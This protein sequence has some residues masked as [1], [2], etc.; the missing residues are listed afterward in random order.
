[1]EAIKGKP[2]S[3]AAL[4]IGSSK[5]SCF[6]GQQHD[7]G[8]IEILGVGHQLAKGIK[9]GQVTDVGEAVE[10][11]VAAVHAAERMAE[12]N[13]EH[14]FV[15]VNGAHVQSRS[16]SV[17]LGIASE[18]VSDQDI[19]D[20]INEGCDSIASE[21][22]SI[23][24]CFPLQ[25]YVDDSKGLRDPRGMLGEFVG[26]EL[27][28]LTAKQSVLTNLAQCLGRCHL[29]VAGYVVAPHAAALA[30]LEKDEREMGVT[31]IDMGGGLTS[32]CVFVDGRNI[33][34][35]TIAIG[36]KHVTSDIAHGLSTSQQNAERIKTLHGSAYGDAKDDEVMIDVPQ[37][38]DDDD[39]SD[40]TQLPRSALVGIIR[41][42][43]EE[44]FEMVRG[45]LEAAGVDNAAGR[46]CV[47]TGGA[48]QLRGAG[49]LA[50]KLLNKQIRKA[51]PRAIQG[52]PDAVSG[53]AFSVVSGLMVFT[54]EHNWEDELMAEARSGGSLKRMKEFVKRWLKANF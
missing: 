53:P 23:L 4:D 1:M 32:I 36:G 5:V 14:V 17:E 35:D 19:V 8:S 16:V 27:H 20:L 28:I 10:S 34:S 3:I 33:F 7:D 12:E 45:R 13:I 9:A 29:N 49:E 42:R 50:S 30:C 26:A 21:E 38:G 25:Y 52:L 15:C 46:R 31:L 40:P 6:I 37:L 22:H 48:S 44:L 43:M 41:P 2:G 39:D 54:A 47:L 11:I 24:H 18:G 51:K